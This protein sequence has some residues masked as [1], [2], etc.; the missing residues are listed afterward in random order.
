MR[1]L[2]AGI[3]ALILTAFPA[4][5]HADPIPRDSSLTISMPTATGNLSAKFGQ[6]GPNWST[7][8][9]GL[10]FDGNTG[11]DVFVVAAGVVKDVSTRGSYGRTVTISHGDGVSSM[12]AHLSSTEVS[13]GDTIMAGERIARMGATGNVT[14]SHLHLEIQA[15]GV[16]TDPYAFLF[17]ANPGT[18][19]TPPAWAC[20]IYRC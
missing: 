13:V 9:S 10:D 15:R 7:P 2:W 20:K 17:G 6:A 16:P 3:L 12:Y 19:S 18:A 1:F 14:G 4:V 8:H 11:D 5:A